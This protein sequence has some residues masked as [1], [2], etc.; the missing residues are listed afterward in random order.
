VLFNHWAR[1][2]KFDSYLHALQRHAQGFSSHELLSLAQND[3]Q[4][5]LQDLIHM[6]LL[7]VLAE[8]DV[9]GLEWTLTVQL[10][11]PV[12]IFNQKRG[13]SNNWSAMFIVAYFE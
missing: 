3:V 2:L 5:A 8:G 7:E 6:C 12:S 13:I 10:R 1:H 4:V 9:L 11:C